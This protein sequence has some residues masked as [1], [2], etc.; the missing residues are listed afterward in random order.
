MK[1]KVYFNCDK[2]DVQIYTLEEFVIHFNRQEINSATDLI[3]LTE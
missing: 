2:E 3:E 1:I